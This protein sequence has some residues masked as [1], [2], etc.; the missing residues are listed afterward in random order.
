[1]TQGIF[2]ALEKSPGA[3]VT[4][5]VKQLG[6]PPNQVHTLPSAFTRTARSA[7]ATH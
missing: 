6:I 4:E 7:R 2:A 1:M 3:K 5:I